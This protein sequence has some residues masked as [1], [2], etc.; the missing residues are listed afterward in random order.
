MAV[1]FDSRC[2]IQR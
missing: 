1:C 2:S